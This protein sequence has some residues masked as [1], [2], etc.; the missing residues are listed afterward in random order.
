MP[1][2]EEEKKEITYNIEGQRSTCKCQRSP[3]LARQ[4]P[5]DHVIPHIQLAQLPHPT[6]TGIAGTDGARPVAAT[7]T[8]R[9]GQARHALA[10]TASR[11][12]EVVGALC[13]A[14]GSAAARTAPAPAPPPTGAGVGA[15]KTEG[16]ATA[17]AG[18]G[19]VL[20]VVMLVGQGIVVEVG[21]AAGHG[22]DALIARVA[23]VASVSATWRGCTG[24]RGWGVAQS[25]SVAGGPSELPAHE[26]AVV[27]R[28]ECVATHAGRDGVFVARISAGV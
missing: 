1:R 16:A 18:A 23:P 28:P 6:I 19:P 3:N 8:Q 7:T 10:A 17:A 20:V 21:I 15:A 25:V 9:R 22:T 4:A 11:V 5:S 12:E 27:G 14:V 2:E 24:G 26:P 13:G